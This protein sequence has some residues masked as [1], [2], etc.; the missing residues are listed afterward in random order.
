MRKYLTNG[1]KQISKVNADVEKVYL[2]KTVVQETKLK[3]TCKLT[4]STK[5]VKFCSFYHP[6]FYHLLVNVFINT[7]S[8]KSSIT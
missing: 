2:R 1:S 7:F 4:D 5:Y 8:G 3:S 6:Y